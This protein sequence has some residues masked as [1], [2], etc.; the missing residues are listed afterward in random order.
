MVQQRASARRA[1]A[2]L[3]ECEALVAR[4]TALRDKP[5]V[6]S[7]EALDVRALGQRIE[8]AS[9]EANLAE[10]ALQGV[11]PQ[12]ARRLKDSPYLRKPTT[13]VLNRVSLPQLTTFLYRLTRGSNLRV[14]SL[15]LS[16][17]RGDVDSG[18]WNAEV[19]LTYLIYEPAERT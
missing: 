13:I 16:A 19:T 7:A 15:R 2:D 10:S 14:R 4:I 8:A 1:A 17:P 18:A 9:Q 12:T 5:A 11:S 6:A 3:A